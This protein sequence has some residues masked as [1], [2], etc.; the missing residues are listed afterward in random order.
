VPGVNS[1]GAGTIRR[2]AQR[3]KTTAVDLAGGPARARVTLTL[4][5]VLGVS[6]ADTG[7]ISSTADNL[8]RAFHIG[9]IQIGLLLAVVSLAGAVFTLPAGVL[10]DCGSRTRLL[11]VSILAWAA[12]VVASGFGAPG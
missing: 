2:A 1:A 11:A 8:E 10:T 12:A 3:V 7:T 5:A 4:A 6:G 9:N